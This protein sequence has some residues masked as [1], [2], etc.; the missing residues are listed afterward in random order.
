MVWKLQ[1]RILTHG[2]AK[3]VALDW[4]HRTLGLAFE[5][6]HEHAYVQVHQRGVLLR[7]TKRW[8]FRT[9]AAAFISWRE[10]TDHRRR[11]EHIMAHIL[12][13]W[14]RRAYASAF[15]RWGD[16]A[17]SQVIMIQSKCARERVDREQ[18]S[19]KG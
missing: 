4:L 15:K 12:K 19:Q 8:L 13:S 1:T 11:A 9:A 10:R 14:V 16:H 3:K 18:G 17:Q 2:L 7:I 6:W 5:T